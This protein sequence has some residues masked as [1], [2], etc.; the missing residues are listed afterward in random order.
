VT[1]SKPYPSMR[2]G[3]PPMALSVGVDVQPLSPQLGWWGTSSGG[4]AGGFSIEPA[5]QRSLRALIDLAT[6]V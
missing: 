4:D 6:A 5:I 3:P 2:W 1:S